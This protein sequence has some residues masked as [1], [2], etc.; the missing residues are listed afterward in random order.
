MNS[1]E[2]EEIPERTVKRSNFYFYRVQRQLF[3]AIYCC[4]CPLQRYF[5]ASVVRFQQTD[6]GQDK[7]QETTDKLDCLTPLCTCMQW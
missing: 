1:Y 7:R 6:N 3:L 2:T 4:L 5:D